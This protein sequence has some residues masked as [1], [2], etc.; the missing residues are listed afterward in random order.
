MANNLDLEEQEQLDQLKHFWKQ[1]GEWITWALI[2][3]FGSIAAYN[4][5]QY[6]QR[7]QAV[8]VA[9]LY[10]EIER[11]AKDGDVVKVERALGD[12]NE[13]FASTA[14]AN[15]AG[16]LAARVL[17][18]KSKPDAAKAAL[19]AVVANAGDPAYT[20]IARIRLAALLTDTKAFGEAAK[21]LEAEFPQEFA[22][23]VADRRGDLAM[24]QDKRDDARA[25]YQKAYKAMDERTEYRRMVEVKLNALGVDVQPVPAPSSSAS[26]ATVSAP[27]A[28]ASK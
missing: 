9:T 19:A 20:A 8:S 23:L 10:D 5:W 18:E 12:I 16:L 17:Y 27:S 11:A 26:S 1:Y 2:V 21:A 3:V 22:G 13:K 25:E 24:A 14:Y 15:Q 4:G 7:K 28:G 6:Y